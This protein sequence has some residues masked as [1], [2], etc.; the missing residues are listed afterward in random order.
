[1]GSSPIPC[2]S[3]SIQYI[4]DFM[5]ELSSRIS[6]HVLNLIPL[7]RSDCTNDSSLFILALSSFTASWQR[8]SQLVK[9]SQVD[10][11]YST[12]HR[13]FHLDILKLIVFCDQVHPKTRP[14][15]VKRYNKL[16]AN[17]QYLWMSSLFC[18]LSMVGEA[19]RPGLELRRSTL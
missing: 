12:V 2:P 13:V 18:F 4:P 19:S 16:M 9:R 7:W 11:D 15:Y 5:D 8:I 6:P 3:G 17:N 1:M 10:S 14:K